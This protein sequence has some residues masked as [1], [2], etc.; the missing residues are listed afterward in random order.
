MTDGAVYPS[1]DPDVNCTDEQIND[2]GM[3]SIGCDFN[4]TKTCAVAFKYENGTM[5]AVDEITGCMNTEDLVGALKEK[6]PK[7]MIEVYPDASGASRKT[8]TSQ[9]DVT[10]LRNAG[11]ILKNPP[12]NPAVK[13]R[14]AC[15]NQAFHQNILK[16]NKRICP[17]LTEALEFQTYD[18]SLRPDKSSGYDHILDAMGY[19]VYQKSDLTKPQVLH[20]DF[21]SFIYG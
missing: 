13:D 11:F 10:I 12:S 7:R 5:Y 8:S 4:V 9:T 6:Y 14:V 15:C 21:R 17:H 1:F 19:Y 20:T 2:H 16:V 3:I 18:S